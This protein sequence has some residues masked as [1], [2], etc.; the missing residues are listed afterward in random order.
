MLKQAV[1]FDAQLFPNT[2]TPPAAA[3]TIDE[4][5]PYHQKVPIETR[6]TRQHFSD[7]LLSSFSEACANCHVGFLFLARSG[8]L[9]G[10]LLL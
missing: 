2:I 4:F 3:R 9:C 10:V 6:Q 7:L 8:F 5:R 1:E